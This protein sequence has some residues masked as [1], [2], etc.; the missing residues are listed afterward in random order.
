MKKKKAFK[1]GFMIYLLTLAGLCTVFLLYV[2]NTMVKYESMQPEGT[3]ESL[4]KEITVEDMDFTQAEQPSVFEDENIMV[5]QMQERLAG[6]D[7]YF[8]QRE[9]SY[10][11]KAPVFDV[12][13]GEDMLY[14]VTLKEKREVRMMF[15]LSASE[16]EVESVVPNVAIGEYAVDIT[17]PDNYTVRVNGITLDDRLHGGVKTPI[18]ELEYS[19]EYTEVP[20]LVTYHIEKLI[21]EPKVEVLNWRQEKVDVS[22]MGGQILIERFPT[23]PMPEELKDYALTAAKTYS[24]FF[25]EIWKAARRAPSQSDIYSRRAPIILKWRKITADMICGC[26]TDTTRR[27]FTKRK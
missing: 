6:A 3:M 15:I 27:R 23:E 22:D 12:Y 18:K 4:I 14:T 24:N 5:T 10:D 25:S 13:D 26:T 11:A 1:I 8:R 20:Q 17:V 2:W 7:L 21:H 16:W 19:G 9:G